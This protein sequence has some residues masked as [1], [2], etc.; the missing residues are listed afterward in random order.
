MSRVDATFIEDLFAPFGPVRVK[1]MFGGAGIYADGLMFALMTGG[2]LYL[3][4]MEAQHPLFEAEGSEPFTYTAKGRTVVLPYW[5]LPE[6][7]FDDPDELVLW[8]RRALAAAR[9]RKA[10]VKPRKRRA[11]NA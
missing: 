1:R 9:E 3:K 11:A 7:L 5:R 6:R 10:A 8:S 4:A 2:V